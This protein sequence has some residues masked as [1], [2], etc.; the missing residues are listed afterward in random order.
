MKNGHTSLPL[1]VAVAD[2]EVQRRALID[3]ALAADGIT[4]Y[5]VTR[6]K[7]VHAVLTASA[8]DAVVLSTELDDDANS[9]GIE[10]FG[11][12][13]VVAVATAGSRRAQRAAMDNGIAALV[14][15]TDVATALAPTVRAVCAGQIVVPSTLR[16]NFETPAL[17]QREKQVL[18]LVVLGFTN[19]EI[20]RKLF[21]AESTVKSHLS[22]SFGKLGVRSRREAAHVIADGANGIG[23]GILAITDGGRL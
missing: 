4:V 3:A 13:P 10:T 22:S 19:G 17:S 20:A 2:A 16:W 6:V 15:D 5:D 18:S 14:L 7:D 9:P 1:T 23:T 21:L 8:I 12:L 11:A